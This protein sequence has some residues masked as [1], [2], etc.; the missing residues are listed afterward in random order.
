VNLIEGHFA[1]C[2]IPV[3]APGVLAKWQPKE[4]D[5]EN[6]RNLGRTIAAAIKK[7]T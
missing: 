6:C 3:A 2:K 7:E 5:L 1:H 4:P